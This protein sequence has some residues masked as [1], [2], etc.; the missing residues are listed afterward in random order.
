MKNFLI[1]IFKKFFSFFLI[2]ISFFIL[3]FFFS[4]NYIIFFPFSLPFF[5]V[6]CVLDWISFV[7]FSI[8]LLISGS[9]LLFNKIYM[10]KDIFFKRFTKILILFIFRMIILIIFPFSIMFFLGWDGLG[11]LSFLLVKYYNSWSSWSARFKTYFLNRLGDGFFILLFSS[12][13]LIKKFWLNDF[14]FWKIS[15][16]FILG[17]F[18][19]SAQIPFRTWL[20]AAMAA[21]TPV[22]SLVHSSTL[23]TAGVYILFRFWNVYKCFFKQILLYISLIT[24]LIAAIAASFEW[25]RKKIIAFSTL[26]NLGIMVFS[27]GLKLFFQRFFHLLTHAVSKAKLFVNVGFM[28]I[29]KNH[30]QDSRL[31]TKKTLKN[32]LLR[33]FRTY[34]ILSLSGIVFFGGFFSKEKI[35]ENNFIL[36]KYFI[37][38]II[39]LIIFFSLFYGFRLIFLLKIKKNKRKKF[40]IF[41]KIKI[42]SI[43]F[44][45]FFRIFLGK[46]LKFYFLKFSISVKFLK[47]I[48]YSLIL[49]SMGICFSIFFNWKIMEFFFLQY[50]KSS[51]WIKNFSKIGTFIYYN[52]DLGIFFN[53][54]KNFFYFFKKLYFFLKTFFV[55]KIEYFLFILFLFIFFF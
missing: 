20:P 40:F 4:L 14:F 31:L 38:K 44:L 47:I 50:F 16:L 29:K 22:S 5:D 33:I 10:K 15:F 6:L 48:Y 9:V 42:F 12:F 23:V 17:C 1:P 26:S 13:F 2:I 28:M 25:D 27:L 43:I 41:S 34:S 30:H 39:Y 21:P 46:I 35:I 53:F 24:S 55:S 3:F 8:L 19:K 18:T 51:F 7:F 36:K 49:F 52:F 37:I 45:T 54:E 11:I 32:F